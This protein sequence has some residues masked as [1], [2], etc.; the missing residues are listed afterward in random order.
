MVITGYF[1]QFLNSCLNYFSIWL[2]K[3]P[4]IITIGEV[5]LLTY[6]PWKKLLYNMLQALEF[7]PKLKFNLLLPKSDL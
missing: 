5:F 3:D 2:V 4:E 1:R 6:L 7:I